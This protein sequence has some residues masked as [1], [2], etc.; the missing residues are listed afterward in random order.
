MGSR[1]KSLGRYVVRGVAGQGGS[2]AVGV[3]SGLFDIFNIF[4]PPKRRRRRRRRR[5]HR[6]RRW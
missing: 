3:L 1:K 6:S 2:I 4:A 5:K